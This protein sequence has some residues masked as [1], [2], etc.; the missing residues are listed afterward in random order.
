MKGYPSTGPEGETKFLTPTHR[1]PEKL[2]QRL[3]EGIRGRLLSKSTILEVPP[4]Q[5]GRPPY[6]VS[7]MMHRDSHEHDV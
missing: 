1:I 4:S 2:L 6:L 7:I 5:K 3:V